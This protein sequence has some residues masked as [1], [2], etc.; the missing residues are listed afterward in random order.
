MLRLLL[1]GVWVGIAGCGK[2]APKGP[3]APPPAPVEVATVERR[4]VPLELTAIGTAESVASVRIRPKVGGEILEVLF[5]DGADVRAGQELFKLDPRPYDA[6]LKR[7]ESNLALAKVKAA[8]AEDQARRY[9]ELKAKGAAS[10]EQFDQFVSTA[11]SQQAE[12]GAREADVEEARLAREWSTVLSPIDGRA[13]AAL[14]KR[15]NIVQANGDVLVVINQ[16]RPIEVAFTLPEGALPDLRRR[17]AQGPLGVTVSDPVTD[18]P[19]ATGNVVF[20][21]NAIDRQSGM[22]LLKARFD[23][24]D[25]ALW[26]GQFLDVLLRLSEGE[27]SLAVPAT[28]IIEGQAGPKVFVVRD[29]VAQMRPVNVE[30]VRAGYAVIGEGVDVGEQV[31]VSGQLRVTPGGKVAVKP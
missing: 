21:D 6:A 30:R 4:A 20:V 3:G 8:N 16:M 17:T 12:K 2:P 11:E 27:G 28:A 1:C 24:A 13:G 26:P 9:T 29:G 25:G 18:Q 23:N 7:A 22:V 10:G 19:V 31:V 5:T 15:G 14:V